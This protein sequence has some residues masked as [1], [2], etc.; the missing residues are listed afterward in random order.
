MVC[1]LSLFLSGFQ[2]P[3]NRLRK[4]EIIFC[5]EKDIDFED[6]VVRVVNKPGFSIKDNEEREIPICDDLA[7]RLK[8]I[9]QINSEKF[10]SPAVI[11]G[12]EYNCVARTGNGTSWKNNL[13]REFRKLTALAKL[14]NVS[15][16]TLRETFGCH[17]IDK[18]VPIETISKL[19][20]HSSIRVTET[21]YATV[22]TKRKISDIQKLN[23]K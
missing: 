12:R 17:L 4:S 3:V 2:I 7:E 20:G 21:H 11:S 18:G 10:D 1:F 6:N 14:E 8:D 9:I 19:L 23:L 15:I 13:D 22:L 16:Q 5:E